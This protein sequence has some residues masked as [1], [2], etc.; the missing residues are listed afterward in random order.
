[1]NETDP[2]LEAL[3][4]ESPLDT[5][6]PWPPASGTSAFDAFIATWKQSCFRPTSFFQRMPREDDYGWVIAYYLVIGIVVSGIELFWHSVLGDWSVMGTLV[7]E[8]ESRFGSIVQFLLSPLILIVTLYLVTSACHLVL[9]MFRG[10]QHG[11]ETSSRVFAFSY[12]PAVFAAVPIVGNLVAF[13]W[14][15]ALA[16]TGLRE[17]HQTDGAKAAV[18]VL[19]PVFLLISVMV[20]AA[21][22]GLMMGILN[23]RI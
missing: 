23:T 11:F 16:I 9:M 14:M 7:P 17:A 22:A 6:F 18:A 3:R 21:I 13:V 19:L 8:S 1:V 4:H 2:Q 5:T 10:A 12:G 20:L 15:I